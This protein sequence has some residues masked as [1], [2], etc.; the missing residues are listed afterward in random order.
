MRSRALVYTV[1]MRR[2]AVAVFVVAACSDPSAPASDAAATPDAGKDA[3][4][5]STFGDQ[6][7][8]AFGRI[9]GTVVA[10]VEPGNPTCAM[11]N[12]DHVV[13]QVE[14]GGA[15][16]RVVVNVQSDRAGADPLVR[17]AVVDAPLPAPAFAPGWHPGLTLDYP[18]DLG[19]HSDAGWD[20]LSLTA[21]TT[22][23]S[24]PIQVGAPIAVY[25][26]SSGGTYSHS[27]H[28]IHRN[29]GDADGALVIDPTGPAPQW[30]LFAFADQTF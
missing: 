9:D 30:L 5:A 19:V 6:L 14:L 12:R 11:P 16:H 3:M 29:G 8:A 26:S 13:V 25:A 18:R 2:F 21:A 27:T 28:L 20:A 17:T 10:V 23:I 24:E 7:T 22:R 4:C 15:T 1:A